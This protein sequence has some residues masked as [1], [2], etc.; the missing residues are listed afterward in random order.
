MK[1]K[2]IA[3]GNKENT[4]ISRANIL[5]PLF[6]LSCLDALPS[7]PQNTSNGCRNQKHDLSQAFQHIFP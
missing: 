1:S 6:L 5:L 2:L 4:V 3:K 7:F